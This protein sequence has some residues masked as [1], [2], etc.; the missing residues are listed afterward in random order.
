MTIE[1]ALIERLE[2]IGDVVA[3][4]GTRIWQNKLPQE[5]QLPAIRVQLIDEIPAYHTRGMTDLMPSRIQVDA[6][7]AERSGQSSYAEVTRL[8]AAIDGAWDQGGSPAPPV[9]LSGWRGEAG[10]SPPSI[11]VSFVRRLDRDATYE[12]GALRLYR[13]RMDYRV[14]WKP[15]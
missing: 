6:F 4:V 10:G 5:P 1:V 14:W 7:A 8:A 12:A 13:V 9:G 3:M 2:S 15:I 11:F